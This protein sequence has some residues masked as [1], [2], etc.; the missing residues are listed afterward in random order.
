VRGYKT[1]YIRI[2]EPEVKRGNACA[3]PKCII[4]LV[5]DDQPPALKEEKYAYQK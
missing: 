4:V 5:A 3:I 2:V 1:L